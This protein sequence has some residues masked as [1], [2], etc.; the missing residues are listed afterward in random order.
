MTKT[1]RLIVAASLLVLLL[2]PLSVASEATVTV[3]SRSAQCLDHP[4]TLFPSV[5]GARVTTSG[6][7]SSAT[8][9]QNA[10]EGR[11]PPTGSASPHFSGVEANCDAAVVLLA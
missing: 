6:C 11:C 4:V 2:A 5:S 3:G 8:A 1:P 9:T 7:E 10:Y